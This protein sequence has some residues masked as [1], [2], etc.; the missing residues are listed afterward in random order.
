[1]DATE[2][3][4][5]EWTV[6]V[7][8]E[9]GGEYYYNRSTQVTQWEEPSEFLNW[10]KEVTN[11]YLKSVESNWRVAG[12][13]EKVYFYN[14]LT[15]KSHWERPDEILQF[16]EFLKSLT[17]ER[18][19][20]F[21]AEQTVAVGT[22]NATPTGESGTV[23]GSVTE[24]PGS[25]LWNSDVDTGGEDVSVRSGDQNCSEIPSPERFSKV[26]LG[27][28]SDVSIFERSVEDG[29]VNKEALILS[30]EKKLNSSD[31]IMLIDIFRT[32]DKYLKLTDKSPTVVV[33]ML[34]DS[35]TGYAKMTGLLLNWLSLVGDET[36]SLT[37]ADNKSD[38]S[39]ELER[40]LND[41]LSK[42]I[43]QKFD[44]ALADDLIKP[45]S[46]VPSWLTVMMNDTTW[47]K[48]LIELLDNNRGSA[49]LGFC[50]KQISAM[51]HHREIGKTILDADYFLVFNN[52]LQDYLVTITTVD[53]SD[54]SARSLDLARMCCNCDYLFF[55]AQEVLSLVSER[56][57]VSDFPE[58]DITGHKRKHEALDEKKQTVEGMKCA[59]F[60][61]TSFC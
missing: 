29:A 35:Y 2:V 16:D 61:H 6:Y 48:L 56:L 31:S 13:G 34:R 45:G 12:D 19:D 50:L 53:E 43:K 27:A 51:G 20:A 37:A 38:S 22:E 36:E 47:R 1:M 52:L 30:L 60:Q 3:P 10:R 17:Q 4:D 57:L 18:R 33:Q 41:L 58:D 9:T 32:V 7:D 15:K 21:D 42:L 11:K 5:I 54:I 40:V 24:L 49:L 46:Q 8:D 44:K 39:V 55:Y 14:K 25:E 28:T 59:L 23:D 26:A